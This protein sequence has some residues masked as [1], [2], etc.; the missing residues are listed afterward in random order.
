MKEE[1]KRLM[2]CLIVSVLYILRAN[3]MVLTYASPI[4]IS[5]VVIT[6]VFMLG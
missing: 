4:A 1:E 6:G 2:I 5:R 3:S